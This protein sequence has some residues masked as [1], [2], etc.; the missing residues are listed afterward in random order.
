[1]DPRWLTARM[2]SARRWSRRRT[3]AASPNTPPQA[4][5][6]PLPVCLAPAVRP[7]H[8]GVRSN[9]PWYFPPRPAVSRVPRRRRTRIARLVS[10]EIWAHGPRRFIMPPDGCHS[11]FSRHFPAPTTWGGRSIILRHSSAAHRCGGGPREREN[12][13][14]ST[15]DVGQLADHR[16][17]VGR[18]LRR[19]DRRRRH[20]NGHV[21]RRV[22]VVHP[23][24]SARGAGG[25]AGR[26]LARR[27]GRSGDRRRTPGPPVRLPPGLQERRDQR[28]GNAELADQRDDLAAD[29][30]RSAADVLVEFREAVRAC[31]SDEAF[32]TAADGMRS[33]TLAEAD[34]FLNLLPVLSTVLHHLPPQQANQIVQQILGRFARDGTGHGSG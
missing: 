6:R 13:R 25:P 23:G 4:R 15:Y 1:M 10:D 31:S 26:R 2:N 24:H 18:L 29:P 34:Q 7:N 21:C 20:G 30:D 28:P 19:H 27:R 8:Q 22:P 11:P 32:A 14:G 17:P 5:G 3:G 12:H 16:G 33:A 9:T